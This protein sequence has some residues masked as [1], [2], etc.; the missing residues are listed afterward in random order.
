MFMQKWRE[1]WGLEEDP[2]NCED[3]DK[4]LILCSLDSSAVHWSF[5]RLYGNPRVAAPAIVFGEKGSGK[6]ALRL[7]IKR[8]VEEFN[9]QNPDGK[10]FLFEYIDFNPYLSQFRRAIVARADDAQAAQEV[11]KRWK[12]ADHLDA[13]LSLGTTKLADEILAMS[14]APKKLTRKQKIYL[15]ILTAI[16]YNSDRQTTAETLHKF[17]WIIKRRTFRMALKWMLIIV[18]TVLSVFVGLLPHLIDKDLGPDQLWYTTGFLGLL[19]S[20]AWFIYAMTTVRALSSWASRSVKILPHN[21]SN[22]NHILASLSTKERKEFV[23]PRGSEEA[24][25]YHLLDR[26]M[27]L[28]E[29]FGYRGVYILLDRFDEPSLLSV[30]EDLIKDFV[31]TLLEIKL[32]QY[33]RLGLKLFLPIELDEIHRNAGPDDLKRMRL[34]KSNLIPELKWSGQELYEIA[35]QRMQVCRAGT[36][37]GSQLADLFEDGFDFIYLKDTLT[38]LGTPRFAFGFFSTLFTEYVKNLPNDLPDQDPRW[39]LPRVHFDVVRAMWIDRSGV[40]RRVLN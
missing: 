15:Q 11:V 23:V 2:F 38:A 7:M 36:V 27:D 21:P 35:N 17:G 24:S 22:L 30:R 5:D 14:E 19:G 33:P 32:L 12:I 20:W 26:F 8:R 1:Y 29:I 3:A 39:K 28:I 13:V 37:P 25:R 10:V 6:S 9:R 4:D 31:K 34:D 16:Y 40:L 18:L